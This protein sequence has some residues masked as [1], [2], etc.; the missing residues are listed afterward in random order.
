MPIVPSTIL[1]LDPG[2]RYLGFAL[3]RGSELLEYGVRE[4][5][6]GERPYD[7]IGQ[8]RRIVLRLIALHGPEVVAIEAPYLIPTPRAAVLSTLTQE[9]H[10]RAK[11]T[12]AT[13]MELKPEEVRVALTGNP[14]ATKYEVAQ[15]LVATRFPELAALVPRKPK[16]PALWLTSRETYRLHMFD[17]LA[18]AVAQSSRLRHQSTTGVM[19]TNPNPTS[20]PRLG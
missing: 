15:R 4:L 1:G 8:A 9:I 20:S 11:E 10:Q 3:L 13:V 6:N 12:G 17:A 18:L 2:T 16:V 5:K 14:K 7:V 19:S